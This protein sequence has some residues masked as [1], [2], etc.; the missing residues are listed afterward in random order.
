MTDHNIYHSLAVSKAQTVS[1]ISELFNTFISSNPGSGAV[2]FQVYEDSPVRGRIPIANAKVTISR[3]LGN[4]YYISK[5][6]TTNA[7]GE[8]EPVMLPTASRE[9]SLRPEEGRSSM[10]YRASVEAPGYQRQDIYDIEI[11]DGITSIQA[12]NMTPVPQSREA[13]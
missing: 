9:R 3:L 13:R 7:T 2:V 8:S 10:T 6:T 11:F 12:V 1:P 5:I 4:D